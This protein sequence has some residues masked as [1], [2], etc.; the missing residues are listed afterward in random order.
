MA[1]I[2]SEAVAPHASDPAY[3]NLSGPDLQI[4]PKTAISFA[5]AIHEL[6]TNA[7]KYGALSRPEGRLAIRWRV[8]KTHK[9]R[10]LRLEWQEFGGPT[11]APPTSRGFGTRMIERG[12]AVE[13][14]GTAQI[15]FATEGVRCVVDAPLPVVAA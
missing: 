3:V 4:A 7:V 15:E 8:M 10:R 11:V 13:L 5:L 6:A 2:I 12:L 14:G 1:S 9:G